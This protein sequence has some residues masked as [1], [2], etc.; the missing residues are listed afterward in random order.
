MM[1]PATRLF[2]FFLLLAGASYATASDSPF[3]VY[4]SRLPFETVMQDL[5]MAIEGKGFYVNNI[6]HMDK[7]MKRTGK[8]LGMDK[9]IFLQAESIEFCSAVLSRRMTEENPNRIVNC[10][11]NISVY[12]LPSKPDTTYIV[13]RRVNLG[14]QSAVMEEVEQMLESLGNVGVKGM[15]QSG[16]D[17]DF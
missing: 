9:Q 6:V 12:V 1:N 15:L 16:M 5:Q 4:E 11:F 17:D 8:D 3:V 13:H 7:M 14:D 10:P 2:G